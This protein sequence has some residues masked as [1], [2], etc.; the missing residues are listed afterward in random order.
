MPLTAGTDSAEEALH[1]AAPGHLREF[2]DRG[3]KEGRE[4]SIDL[5]VD[6]DDRDSLTRR[7]SLGERAGAFAAVEERPSPTLLV[8]LDGD[9]V[10]GE[11]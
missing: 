3:E 1:V 8:L 9:V 10:G 2:V 11:S 5:F 4:E 7:L 6:R